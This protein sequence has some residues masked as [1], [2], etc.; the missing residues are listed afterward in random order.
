[1]VLALRGDYRQLQDALALVERN[2][3][4]GRRVVE[5]QRARALVLALQP[6]RRREAI[7]LLE[8]LLLRQLPTADEQFLLARLYE[9]DRNWPKAQDRWLS[10][11]TAPQGANPM[12]LAHYIR[13]VLRRGEKDEARVWLARLEK[14]EPDT[15]RTIE[16]KAHV[17]KAEGKSEEAVALLRTRAQ[18]KEDDTAR[19]AALL[20][21][22]GE[23]AAAED[24]YRKH[25]ARSKEPQNALALAEHLGRRQRVEEALAL[26]EQ[27]WRTCPPEAVAAASVGV[28]RAGQGDARQCQAVERRLQEAVARKPESPVLLLALAELHDLQGRYPEA[29]ASYRAVLLRDGN[30]VVALNNLAWLVALKFGKGA[31]GLE[32]S[33]RALAGAG[34]LPDLLDTRAAVHLT[35]GQAGPALEDLG[36]AI[37]EAPTGAKYFHLAQAHQLGKNRNAAAVALGKARAAGLKAA[38]LHPLERAA[39]DRLLGELALK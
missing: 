38:D 5:D 8:D 30:N 24:M 13:S 15:W 37:A 31:E 14:Q 9:A 28:L 6:G 18:G 2:M 33:N 32:L 23:V 22:L 4:V 10:L 39:Y 35:L 26:C 20:E 1:M 16:I 7:A 12:H 29:E 19:V 27:S 34:P 17:L 3:S 21:Q 25:V 36:P 11:L